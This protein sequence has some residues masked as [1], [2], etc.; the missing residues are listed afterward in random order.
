MTSFVG[1]IPTIASGD[2]TTVPTNLATYRDA[3]KGLSEAWTAFTP[4][5]TAA[6]TNPVLGNGSF[7]GSAY[8]RVNKKI[9]FRIVLTMGSTTTYGTGIW[10]FTPP[11]LAVSPN[12]NP[13]PFVANAYDTGTNFYHCW[14][15]FFTAGSLYCYCDPTAAGGAARS[16]TVTTPFTWGTGDQFIIAG[17]YEAA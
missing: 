9:D 14:A 5:W 15:T 11:V 7:T 16:V 4:T 1:T 6:T 13:I 17:S 2:T 3:L 10:I 12:T 8:S